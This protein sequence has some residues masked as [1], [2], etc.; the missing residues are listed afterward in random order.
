MR[1]NKLLGAIAVNFIKWNDDIFEKGL[2]I[3]CCYVKI[4]MDGCFFSR[5]TKRWI[6]FCHNCI[7]DVRKK[8]TPEKYAE[9][10]EMALQF[11]KL[12][13]NIRRKAME[14]LKNSIARYVT[15]SLQEKFQRI[16][17]PKMI[18]DTIHGYNL[19]YKHEILVLDLP[20]MQRLRYISQVD[21]VSLVFLLPTI[22]ALNI[23]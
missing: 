14:S 3:Q 11:E 16:R 9:I 20:L 8:F 19:F 21:L 7:W 6:S 23:S 13:A 17:A 1:V 5:K 18:H 4:K 22:I 10:K 15:S 12:L 2:Q